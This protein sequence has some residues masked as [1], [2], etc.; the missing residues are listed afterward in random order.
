MARLRRSGDLTP[1]DGPTV[2]DEAIRDLCRARADAS[3]DLK[4]AT[5][6]LKALWLRHDM[7]ATGR[8]TWS[9]AHRRGLSDVVCPP[10][11]QPMVLHASVR[12]GNAPAARR[13]R[14]EQ[15]RHEH[16]PSWRLPPVVA[17]LPAWRGVQ[18]IVAV[19][20]VADRGDLPRVDHPRPLLDAGGL[21]PSASSRGP[22]RRPGA[23]PKAGDSH[24]RRGLVAGAWASRAPAT[25]SRPFQRRRETPPN[26]LQD[27]RGKAHGRLG[28]RE[29]QLLARGKHA[30]HVGVAMARERVGFMWAMATEGAVTPAVHQP[31]RHG[32]GRP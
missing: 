17:A 8:A 15:A 14:L 28:T 1:V 27:I 18:C 22:C 6:R 10:P 24:G 31:A 13:P 21:P 4:A 30:N 5:F 20:A 26:V 12:A 23:S 11:A 16:G 29:R 7:R 3:R 19:P 9:P 32:G 25:V 2:E